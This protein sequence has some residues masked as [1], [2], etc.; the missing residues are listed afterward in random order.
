MSKNESPGP[1]RKKVV[2]TLYF[3]AKN[4][5]EEHAIAG[6]FLCPTCKKTTDFK[7]HVTIPVE[8]RYFGADQVIYACWQCGKDYEFIFYLPADYDPMKEISLKH[9]E[10][11]RG[12]GKQN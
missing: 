1:S 12:D 7:S 3:N 6:R 9:L 10:D 2:L 5:S 8:G 11:E 4:P